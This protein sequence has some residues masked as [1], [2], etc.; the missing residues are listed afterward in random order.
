M[1]TSV[2]FWQGSHTE[3][4]RLN[5]VDLLILTSLDQLFI[6]FIAFTFV[7]KQAALMRRSSVES[8]SFNFA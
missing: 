8:L 3:V 5:S 6:Q 7:T 1:V 2:P 4:G